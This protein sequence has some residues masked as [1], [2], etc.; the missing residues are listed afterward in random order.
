MLYLPSLNC[1]GRFTDF[2]HEGSASVIISYIQWRL[3]AEQH[4]TKKLQNTAKTQNQEPARAPKQPP[5]APRTQ[6]EQPS[7][8]YLYYTCFIIDQS[9]QHS[10]PRGHFKSSMFSTSCRRNISVPRR[11]FVQFSSFNETRHDKSPSCCWRLFVISS[12][13]FNKPLAVNSFHHLL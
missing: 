6:K 2:I 9:L 10:I 1:W 4:R 8:P 3:K 7:L 5:A 11:R 12:N 13:S